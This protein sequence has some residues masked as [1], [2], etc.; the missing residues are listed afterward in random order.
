MVLEVELEGGGG[1]MMMISVL[2]SVENEDV[3]TSS[4]TEFCN[5]HFSSLCGLCKILNNGC[6][7]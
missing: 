4:V 5:F 2:S 6:K 7:M 1:M 3:R